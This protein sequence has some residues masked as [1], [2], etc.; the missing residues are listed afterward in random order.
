MATTNKRSNTSKESLEFLQEKLQEFEY[1][2]ANFSN[3][4]KTRD[5]NDTYQVTVDKISDSSISALLESEIVKDVF[6]HPSMAPVGYGISLRYRLY[7]S[8]NKVP[9]KRARARKSTKN[10]TKK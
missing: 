6:Y 1:I 5:M 9:L 7:V 10:D 2:G 3:H 4:K 8:Y